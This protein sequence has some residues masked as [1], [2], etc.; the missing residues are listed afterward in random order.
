MYCNISVSSSS[1][2]LYRKCTWKWFLL[3]VKTRKWTWLPQCFPQRLTWLSSTGGLVM[4][5]RYMN[6]PINIYLLL[7]IP[8][9][10]YDIDEALTTNHY[11][12]WCDSFSPNSPWRGLCSR[13]SPSLVRCPSPSRPPTAAP[14]CRTPRPCVCTVRVSCVAK[15]VPSPNPPHPTK[16]S[17]LP[18]PSQRSGNGPERCLVIQCM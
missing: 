7:Y 1:K 3:L 5:C 14:W 9:V 8:I 16:K 4:T 6:H 13:G 17:N 11:C 2:L 10:L 18:A 15:R 12:F